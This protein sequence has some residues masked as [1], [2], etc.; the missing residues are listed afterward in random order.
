MQA[1][2][3][4]IFLAT[5]DFYHHQRILGS[6]VEAVK[7]DRFEKTYDETNYC[8]NRFFCHIR[9]RNPVCNRHGGG[10]GH[11]PDV[12]KCLSTADKFF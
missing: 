7:Q 6:F 12:G 2:E 10:H 5:N 1:E 8:S 4:H 11:Q 3:L 9:Q